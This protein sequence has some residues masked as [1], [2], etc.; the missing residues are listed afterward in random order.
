MKSFLKKVLDQLIASSHPLEDIWI[1]LPSKRA[2]SYLKHL[3]KTTTTYSGF[4]PNVIS[5]EEF[6]VK[7]TGLHSLDNTNTLFKFYKTYTQLTPKEEQ[8]DF[9]TFY[10]WAQTLIYDFNEIDRYLINSETFFNY[11]ADIKDLEHWSLAQPQT[12]LVH[13]YL[14]FWNRLPQYHQH[15]VQQLL[16]QKEA[17]QG[18]IYRKAAEEIS[19]FLKTTDNHFVFAGFNALNNAEQKIIQT[20]LAQNRG[21]IYW[22]IDQV[23][24]E[25]KQHDA[26]LFIRTYKNNWPIYTEQKKN[27]KWIGTHY[28]TPKEIEFIGI[29]KN[30]GQAKYIGN[31]LQTEGHQ[32]S[33]VVLNDE[34]LLFP[35][36]NTLPKKIDKV[37]I[38]MGLP[39]S[40]TPVA[41][42]F[43][44]LFK[45]Q[46][47]DTENLY[48][49]NVLDLLDHP[50]I[51]RALPKESEKI[52]HEIIQ[53]NKAFIHR[54]ELLQDTQDEAKKILDLCFKNHHQNIPDLLKGIG[55]LIQLL[56]PKQPE[57]ETLLSEYLYHFHGLFQKLNNLISSHNPIRQIKTL[58][59][60]YNDL[61]DSETLDFSGSPFDGLQIMGML[62]TRVLD[63]ETLI[64][65]SVNEG[66]LPAGKS[67]NSFIPYDL[68]RQ[69]GLP[70]YKEKDAVYTYHFY[71]LLQRAKKVYILYNTEKSGLN[72]GEKS[73]FIT[74]LEVE[75]PSS[76]TLRHTAAH[77]PVNP[78]KN[79]LASIPKN[80]EILALLIRQVAKGFSPSAL[81]TYIRNPLDFYKKYVLHIGD[82]EEV[83]ETVAA[84][85]LGTVV[86][87]TLENLYTPLIGKTLQKEDIE[88]MYSQIETEVKR[89]FKENYSD[90]PLEEGKNKIIF[91]VAKRYVYNFLKFEEKRIAQHRIK[92]LYIESGELRQQIEI[93]ELDFPIYIRGRVDRVEEIDGKVRVIDYKTGKVKP[94][95]LKL[96]EPELLIT[97]KTYNKAFQV[98]CY[99]SMLRQNHG[100]QHVEAGIISFKNL[101]KGF[102]PFIYQKAD[103]KE[104]TSEIDK[105]V[106]NLFIR[107]LKLL[108]TE[109]FD[110]TSSFQEKEM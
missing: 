85:T 63:F 89:Q 72:A 11:L 24:L 52:Q 78:I 6:I 109:I 105:N 98:L 31:L 94:E 79:E 104:K 2:G 84:N 12:E 56:R 45:L 83:E 46:Q 106:V 47:E 5:T 59:R 62:E 41:A 28:N 44:L 37:N 4:T 53:Q 49:K 64:I 20:I 57:K 34:G 27:F 61:L 100:Y 75:A 35:L 42:F 96:S 108:I 33:A 86:H 30:I 18:L 48:Y 88:A 92:I 67:T 97:D 54:E 103:S 22:D 38:T 9:E 25:D 87:N 110:S 82:Q 90:A 80:D 39:L 60:I 68:K 13:H 14:K 36:L 15:F 3:L 17:Y 1:I 43:E 51:N 7:I 101:G 16:Q 23:F 74:Q 40:K 76:F 73:R 71:R 65:S 10:G 70:T 95:D 26:G 58:Q 55:E 29:P 93:P 102:M 77:A 107:E 8:E 81:T 21:D 32:Q 99:A 66:V 91:E 50:L 19:P 69:Y